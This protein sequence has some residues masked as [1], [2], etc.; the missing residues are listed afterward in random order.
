MMLISYEVAAI[1]IPVVGC[2][3]LIWLILREANVGKLNL[4]IEPELMGG[5]PVHGCGWRI[6]TEAVKRLDSRNALR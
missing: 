5:F 3:V 1:L 4:N 6:D 2:A